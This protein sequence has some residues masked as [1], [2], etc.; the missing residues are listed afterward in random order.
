MICE[1]CTRDFTADEGYIAVIE[2]F[3]D[4]FDEV[5]RFC[6]IRCMNRWYQ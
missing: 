3:P 6:S 2:R 1:Q 4:G 5:N